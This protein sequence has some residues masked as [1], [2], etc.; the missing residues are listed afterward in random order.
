MP[1][2]R[3]DYEDQQRF[4]AA[5][6][7]LYRRSP[8][9]LRRFA[10]IVEDEKRPFHEVIGAYS[11]IEPIIKAFAE[12]A[13]KNTKANGDLK[14]MFTMDPEQLAELFKQQEGGRFIETVKAWAAS[15]EG[16]KAVAQH[17]IESGSTPST[18]E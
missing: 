6:F 2:D 18:P 4:R 12:S 16:A 7:D 1:A 14:D 3:I 15:P 11:K 5:I 8:K 9:F 10:D 13:G 17:Q